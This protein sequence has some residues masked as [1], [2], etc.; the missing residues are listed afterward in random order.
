[1]S[2]QKLATAPTVRAAAC[3]SVQVTPNGAFLA[4]ISPSLATGTHLLYSAATVAA[5]ES[6]INR[7]RGGK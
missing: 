2:P 4:T 1:M 3:A 6:E 7:L 5:L